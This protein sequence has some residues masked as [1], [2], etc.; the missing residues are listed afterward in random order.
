VVNGPADLLNKHI[1]TMR[2]YFYPGYMTL[3]ADKSIIR[4]DGNSEYNLLARLAA[5][6]L[7]AIL[8]KKTSLFIG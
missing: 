5:G 1:G 4:E 8:F 7:D 6:R 2:G 3:F